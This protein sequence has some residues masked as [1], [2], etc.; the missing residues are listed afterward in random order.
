MRHSLG[1]LLLPVISVAAPGADSGIERSGIMIRTPQAKAKTTE[2]KPVPDGGYSAG[3]GAFEL[4]ATNFVVQGNS[5]ASFNSSLD[6][7]GADTVDRPGGRQH[8]H[9]SDNGCSILWYRWSAIYDG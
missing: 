8:G 4:L 9:P 7:M 3:S 1:I 5:C 2:Q 6:F